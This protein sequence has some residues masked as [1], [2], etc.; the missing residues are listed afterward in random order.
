MEALVKQFIRT[1]VLP[2]KLH[3]M[4]RDVAEQFWALERKLSK[5]YMQDWK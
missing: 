1:D 2:Q 3:S 5:T 4:P